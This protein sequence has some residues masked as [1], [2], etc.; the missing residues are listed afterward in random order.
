MAAPPGKVSDRQTLRNEGKFGPHFKGQFWK[1]I[2]ELESSHPSQPVRSP[3]CFFRVCEN[4]RHSRGLGWRAGVS[5]RQILGMSGE[6]WWLCGASLRSPFSNFRFGMR[7]T[8]SMCGG[9]RFAAP[10]NAAGLGEAGDREI[11]RPGPID[12]RRKDAGRLE[13]SQPADVPFALVLHAVQSHRIRCD[14][15]LSRFSRRDW[16]K[17]RRC[18]RSALHSPSDILGALAVIEEGSARRGPGQP[19]RQ[20]LFRQPSALRALRPPTRHIT[21]DARCDIVHA[22]SARPSGTVEFTPNR[23]PDAIWIDYHEGKSRVIRQLLS[24]CEGFR[25]CKRSRLSGACDHLLAQS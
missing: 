19:A 25:R 6:D 7:E 4:R 18:K 16:G 13:R 2:C 17:S 23:V 8:G 24:H 21:P 3:L 9:D 10:M 20:A 12:D 1:R 14:F 15:R 22:V 5:G 11:R